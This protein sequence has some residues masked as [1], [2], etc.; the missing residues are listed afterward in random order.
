MPSTIDS[1]RVA[2]AAHRIA[3][4]LRNVVREPSVQPT[5]VAWLNR[6]RDHIATSLSIEPEDFNY[7]PFSQQAEIGRAHQLCGPALN[8]M[9]DELNLTLVA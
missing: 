5:A 4:L 3:P 7:A 6:I 8:G 2:D 1:P 9:L